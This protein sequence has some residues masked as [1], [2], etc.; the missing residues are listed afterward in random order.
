VVTSTLRRAGAADFASIAALERRCFGASDGVF[1]SRQLRALLVNPNAYWLAGADGG[2]M[3]C[4]LMARNG[5]ARWARLY[6]LA[7]DP[8]LRGQG[9]GGRLLAAGEAWMREQGLT[10]CRAEVKAGNSSARRLYASHGYRET[11]TLPDYYGTGLDGVRLVKQ[12]PAKPA[13]QAA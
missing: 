7:V 2:A 4:W 13:S 6:S 10:I 5:H 1:N 12:L 9:W 3:A 11:G 8:A